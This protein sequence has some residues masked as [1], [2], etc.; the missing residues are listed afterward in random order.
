METTRQNPSG[1]EGDKSRQDIG[2]PRVFKVFCNC[3]TRRTR[4]SLWNLAFAKPRI[5]K[6]VRLLARRSVLGCDERDS[7]IFFAQIFSNEAIA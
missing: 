5:A 6:P 3:S 1:M 2:R 7:R 4:V